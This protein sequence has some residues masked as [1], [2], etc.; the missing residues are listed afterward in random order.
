VA[1]L[2]TPIDQVGFSNPTLTA[3]QRHLYYTHQQHG[4]DPEPYPTTVWHA[5]WDG[6]RFNTG[7]ELSLTSD[8]A[9]DPFGVASPAISA[10]GSELWFSR[11][12]A[13]SDPAADTGTDIWRSTGQGDTW[14][15]PALVAELSSAFDDSARPPAVGGT[16]MPLSSKRHGGSLHQI[17]FATRAADGSWGAPNQEHLGNINSP[18]YLSA[19]GFLSADGLSLYFASTRTG[20][21]DLYVARRAALDADFGAPEALPPSL[22]T[23]FEERMPWLSADETVLYFTSTRS[24]QYELY[25][26]TRSAL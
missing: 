25:V 18:D 10:D 12:I 22:N 19:D 5:V 2:L 9:S 3:D 1:P 7:S 24:G 16:L 20:D 15:E 8:A 11:R 21:A 17:Y 4:G 13:V 26:A 14:S 6:A 23:P